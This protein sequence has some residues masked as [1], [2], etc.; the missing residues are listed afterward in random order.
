MADIFAAAEA[1]IFAVSGQHHQAIQL[2]ESVVATAQTSGSIF[3]K[4]LAERAWAIALSHISPTHSD[5]IEAHLTTSLQCFET[6]E[7]NMEAARTHVAWGKIT[8]TQGNKMAALAHFQKAA[9]QFESAETPSELAQ[10]Q[11]LIAKLA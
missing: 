1:E 3:A 8:Q 10:V 5:E 2:A 9:A 4:G 6:G 7:N 11:T